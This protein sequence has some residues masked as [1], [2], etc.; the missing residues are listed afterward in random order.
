V[1]GQNFVLFEDV[2]ADGSGEISFTLDAANL[3]AASG[4]E[5]RLG[6]NGFQIQ[7][8]VPEPSSFALAGLSL[9][10]L[11]FVVWHRRRR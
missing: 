11:G 8:I 5:Y 7:A 1:S 6:L 2:V 4:D 3:T 9:L 10:S